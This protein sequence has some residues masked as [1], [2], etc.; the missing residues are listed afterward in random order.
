MP[1]ILT[2]MTGEGSPISENVRPFDCFRKRVATIRRRLRPAGCSDVHQ[3][4][5]ETDMEISSF[6]TQYPLSALFAAIQ[7][8]ET[9][10][11]YPYFAGMMGGEGEFPL[12]LI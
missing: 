6:E 3:I 8:H 7:P 12:C 5:S 4:Y 9:R 2:Y 10:M 1:G 11:S